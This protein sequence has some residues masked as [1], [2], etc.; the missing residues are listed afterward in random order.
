MFCHVNDLSIHLEAEKSTCCKMI[1]RYRLQLQILIIKKYNPSN[2]PG[3]YKNH[4]VVIG[5]A[6]IIQH[7]VKQIFFKN[8]WSLGFTSFTVTVVNKP[9]SHLTIKAQLC[10]QHGISELQM[11]VIPFKL[12]KKNHD[13]KA[14]YLF[15]SRVHKN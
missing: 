13:L 8:I 9:R 5:N 10:L 1:A 2:S 11:K 6:L 12:D 4:F 14:K 7:N 3:I 15:Q